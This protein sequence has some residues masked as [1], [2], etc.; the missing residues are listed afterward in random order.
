MGDSLEKAG[1]DN[2]GDS[3]EVSEVETRLHIW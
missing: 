2:R 3:G 1:S